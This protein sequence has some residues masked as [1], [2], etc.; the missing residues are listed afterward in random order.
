M[1]KLS[2]VFVLLAVLFVN[3]I[4]TESLFATD[5]QCI[6]WERSGPNDPWKEVEWGDVSGVVPIHLRG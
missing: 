4:F 2:A 3:S 5:I 6:R 1:K